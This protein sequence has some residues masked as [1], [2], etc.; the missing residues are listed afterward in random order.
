MD[1]LGLDF[2]AREGRE[3]EAVLAVISRHRGRARAVSMKEVARVTGVNERTVQSIVKQLVEEKH[4][5]IGT[6][7]S[8]PY[9][10]FMIENEAER[11]AVR[12]HLV[13]RALSTLEHAR[14]FDSD[15]IV[16]PLIGQLTLV[17]AKED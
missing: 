15:E 5:P 12:N 13:R 7:T 14:A 4:W 9:G 2:R 11:R 17:A 1:Q 16:A 10:Y 6:A 3:E 8:A